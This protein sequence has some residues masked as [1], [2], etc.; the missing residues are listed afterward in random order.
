[1]IGVPRG[2]GRLLGGHVFAPTC[3]LVLACALACTLAGCG[4]GP[5]A[6]V[7]AP[8]LYA[9]APSGG[10]ADNPFADVPAELQTTSAAVVY[11]TDREP[12]T[13]EGV[14]GYS[15]KRSRRVSYGLCTVRM[16]EPETTWDQLVSASRT[17]ERKEPVPL[18]LTNIDER[19]HWLAHGSAV[20]VNGRWVDN[21][22]EVEVRAAETKKLHSLLAERLALTP[23]KE[24]F[25][26]VHGYNNSFESGAFRASQ[27]WHFTGLHARPRVGRVRQ[28]ARQELPSRSGFMSGGE[29]DSPHRTQPRDG[30]PCH[31]CARIAYR[32]SCRRQGHPR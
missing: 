20:E 23:R 26:F 11:A 31:G 1:M 29:E 9:D 8:N 19:G 14:Y 22:E 15:A 6:M 30:H 21:P 18:T 17:H 16:G 10:A 12:Q 7:A 4:G 2:L 27:I 13:V 5:P 24:L 25:V 3:A 32:N 28:S